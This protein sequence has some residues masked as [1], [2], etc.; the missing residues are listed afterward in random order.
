MFSFRRRVVGQAI[1]N[2]RV[3]VATLGLAVAAF[4]LVIATFSLHV[5]A[6]RLRV[7]TL[8]EL[9]ALIVYGRSPSHAT[10]PRR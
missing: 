9:L 8:R 3:H 1:A 7:V 10:A 4:R 2:R 6:L 5:A